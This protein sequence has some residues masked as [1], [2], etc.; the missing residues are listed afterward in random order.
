MKSQGLNYTLNLDTRGKGNDRNSNRGRSKSRNSNRNRSK[1]R[2]GQQVQCWNYGKAGHFKRHCKIPKKKNNDDS[3]NS[4]TDEVQDALLL[5]VDSP[6]DDWILDSR[7]SFHT[8][9]HQEII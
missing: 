4:L 1:S 3:T 2:S 7:A 6:L 9:P 5:V 8:T